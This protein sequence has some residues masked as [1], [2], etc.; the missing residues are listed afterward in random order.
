MEPGL[1]IFNDG[2]IREFGRRFGS[3]V[4]ERKPA[5][6]ASYYADKAIIVAR[7]VEALGCRHV[8]EE[9]WIKACAHKA[10]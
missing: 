9:F 4:N 2:A 8:I 10:I 7:D 6:I 3:S 5:M 1:M